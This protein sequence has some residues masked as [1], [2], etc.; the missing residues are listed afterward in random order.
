MSDINQRIGLDASDIIS[1]LDRLARAYSKLNGAM[2][3]V[4]AS[5]RQFSQ[6]INR[7]FRGFQDAAQQVGGLARSLGTIADAGRKAEQGLKGAGEADKAKNKFAELQA[8]ATRLQNSL[9]SLKVGI[10]PEAANQADQIIKRIAEIGA[11]A[12]LSTSQ[13]ISIGNNLNSAMVGP[14]GQIQRLIMQ[15]NNLKAA[16]EESALATEKK[17]LGFIAAVTAANL[18][19]NAISKLI[20]ATISGARASVEFEL[21]IARIAT[22]AGP[23]GGTI[24]NLGQQVRRLSEKFGIPAIEVAA[25]QYELLSNQIG[26]ATSSLEVLEAA[27]KLSATTG[28]TSRAS[29]AALSSVINSYGLSTSQAADIA[30]KFF[31]AVDLGRF[32][33]EDIGDT[34][35]RVTVS[36]SQMGVSI[37]EVLAALATLT[38]SGVP[39]A[40]ALTLLSNTMRGLLKPTEDTE[41]AMRKL[42]VTTAEQGIQAFGGFLPFLEKLVEQGGETASAIAQMTE[43]IRV[44]RGVLGLTGD[45]ARVAAENLRQISAAGREFLDQKFQIIVETNAQQ[46][47][48]EVAEIGNFFKVEIGQTALAAINTLTRPIGGLSG[49]VRGLTTATVGLGA[50]YAALKVQAFAAAG[51]FAALNAAAAT[52]LTN[53]TTIGLAVGRFAIAAAPVAALATA[54]TLLGTQVSRVNDQIQRAAEL[55]IKQIDEEARRQAESVKRQEDVRTQ[56]VNNQIKKLS[57][58]AAAAQAVNQQEVDSAI[59]AQQLVQNFYIEQIDQRIQAYE[60]FVAAVRAAENNAVEAARTSSEKIFQLRAQFEQGRFERS[61]SGLNN[62]QQ[63]TAQIQRSNDLLN[64]AVALERAGGQAAAERA[65]F[66]REQAA[67]LANAAAQSAATSKNIALRKRAEDQVARVVAFQVDAEE[68]RAA[69]AQRAAELAR[70]NLAVE[71][72][73]LSDIKTLEDQIKK[74]Q[75]EAFQPTKTREEMLETLR[76]ALPIAG[77]LEAKLREAGNIDLAKQL[78]LDDL[79][80]QIR[81]PFFDELGRDVQLRVG[82]GDAI[83]RLQETLNSQEFIIKVR[84]LIAPL[85]EATGLD[86]EQ[87]ISAG[88]DLTKVQE[89]LVQAQQQVTK[90]TEASVKLVE[91][92][93]EFQSALATVANALSQFQNV[94]QAEASGID[95]DANLIVQ[96]VQRLGPGALTEIA[97]TLGFVPDRL[98]ATA[99]K[100]GAVQQTVNTILEQVQRGQLAPAESLLEAISRLSQ[101]ELAAGNVESARQL[102]QLSTSLSELI[103]KARELQQLQIDVKLREDAIQRIQGASSAL[104]PLS[105]NMS[106]AAATASMLGADVSTATNTIAAGVSADFARANSASAMAAA[107][108]EVAAAAREMGAAIAAASAAGVPGGFAAGGSVGY[109]QG[110]GALP[111]GRDT[112]PAMLSPGEFVI[113]SRSA[114]KFF[115]QLA[116]INSAKPP[117]FRESGGEVTNVSVGDVIVNAPSGIKTL[118][119]EIAQALNRELRKGTISLRS[120]KR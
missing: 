87:I 95:A 102:Q 20:N 69:Q 32:T 51:G 60:K 13:I 77:E 62:V 96:A 86:V 29:V 35:G 99:Q 67:Q 38:I 120:K 7:A 117:V 79:I 74:I 10:P 82:F 6:V 8:A 115:P 116:A 118:G 70:Q 42:G 66:L 41:K 63:V 56:S 84:P 34:I 107:F 119:R 111:R 19:S 33:L 1:E 25:A 78:R 91:A 24:E 64:K 75:T 27:L 76:K 5:G 52:T 48:Q 21:A 16:Q 100:F 58:L 105:Q 97:T 83:T 59:R 103:R 113:N 30:G 37:D 55:R 3:K 90:G 50:A 2:E 22:I 93:G 14:Q 109:F 49:L 61:L 57:E 18:L 98:E 15:L 85:G 26:N 92:Q 110:G 31:K 46:V 89:K 9:S 12:Q 17:R 44:A 112:I 4:I 114:R 53:L 94:M 40:E 72:K 47:R 73:R 106:S 28:D 71:E 65:A 88:G 39:P 54:V 23:V 36:A 11:K 104:V 80:S 81:R 108:S 43:N 45:Q 101:E 68:R